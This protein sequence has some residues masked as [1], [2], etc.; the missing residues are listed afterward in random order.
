MNASPDSEYYVT[1]GSAFKGLSTSFTQKQTSPILTSTNPFY[2]TQPLIKLSKQVSAH[3]K[4]SAPFGS[5]LFG[6]GK[7]QSPAKRFVT[8]E[9]L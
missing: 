8:D 5:T 7:P 1:S 2:S 6:L 4:P 9:E 3:V